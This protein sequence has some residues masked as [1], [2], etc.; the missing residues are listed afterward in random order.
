MDRALYAEMF[1]VEQT[2][3][4]FRAKHRIVRD[5][6][7]RYLP[8]PD[9]GA[10]RASPVRIADLGCGCGGMLAALAQEYD[11]TGLDASPE[12]AAFSAQRGIP[13]RLGFLPDQ[14][15]LPKDA[16]DAALLLDVLEHLDDDAGSVAAA[17]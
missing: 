5:L 13:V 9:D 15:P 11:V 4:W 12:A 3:W 10:F 17:A 16:F 14:V 6:L 8:R 2:H 1:A 7:G